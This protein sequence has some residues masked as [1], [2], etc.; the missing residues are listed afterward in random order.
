VTTDHPEARLLLG[1][2][3][4]RREFVLEGDHV[5][6]GRAAACDIVLSDETV[7]RSH[8]RVERRGG[9]FVIEDLG[10]PNGTFVN[11]ARVERMTLSPGDTIVLGKST[12]RFEAGGETPEPD[13]T[14]IA[15]EAELD[16]ILT[17][18]A[19]T[20]RLHNSSDPSLVVHLAGKTWEVPLSGDALTVGRH[21]TNDIVVET[22]SA[23][24]Q[25]ARVER[26]GDAVSIHDLESGNGTRVNGERVTERRLEDGDTI[27]IGDARFVFK[28]GVASAEQTLAD[29]TA[30]GSEVLKPVVIVPGLMGSELWSGNDQVWPNL[31][32]IFVHPDL[33]AIS[34]RRPLEARRILQQVVIVPNLFKKDK[35][36]RLGNY[37]EE[38]LGYERGKNLLEFAYDWRQDNRVSARHLANAIDEWQRRSRDAARP[39]TI[40]AHS[41]G[42]LVSRYYVE[43]LGGKE[44]V[45]RMI[46]L[47]GPHHGAPQAI[48][49]LFFG[50]KLLPFGLVGERLRDVVANFPAMYQLLPT[51]SC[52]VDQAGERINVLADEMW[53][54][55]RQRALL[56]D[57]RKF[58]KELGTR[59]SVPAICIFGYGLRTITGVSVHRG[60]ERNWEKVQLSTG[61]GDDMVPEPS[62][63]LKGAEIHPVKQHH[64]ALYTDKDVKQR[65]KLELTRGGR[66]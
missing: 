19:V 33:L 18:E 29:L 59:S 32:R 35:Y 3:D 5:L 9:G 11:G 24:R 12:L 62:A 51:Y 40:V 50:P 20:V 28:A 21:P 44:K 60:S 63:V 8:A 52:G 1:E 45:E 15:T 16:T 7:S 27:R 46:F 58:R 13:V 25:H 55:E 57:A 54:S 38:G 43:H 10:T 39:I 66:R 2:P 17:E 4:D 26:R 47:G 23:S 56:R 31:K 65:L 37:L 53:I 14:T 30:T 49:A 42:S 64:G 22:P 48:G 34:E 6:V 61:Q 41:M 36:N